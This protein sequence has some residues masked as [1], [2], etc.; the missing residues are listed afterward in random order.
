MINLFM[1]AGGEEHGLINRM[2]NSVTSD[3]LAKLNPKI[4]DKVMRE[5]QEDAR[6]IKVKYN[7]YRGRHERLDKVYCRYAG[8]TMEQW[9]LIP[10]YTYDLPLGFIKE[11]N[12]IKTMQRSGLVA[13]DGEEVSQ[14]GEPLDKDRDGERVHELVPINFI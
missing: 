8:D 12:G 3:H 11:V 14:D 7:N 4:K 1:T 10:G 6:V 5:K 2:T 9:H 13:I